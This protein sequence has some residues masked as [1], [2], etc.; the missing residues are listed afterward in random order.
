MGSTNIYEIR[1]DLDSF[2]ILGQIAQEDNPTQLEMADVDKGME[3]IKELG[4][5]LIE[6]FQHEL[7]HKRIQCFNFDPLEAGELPSEMAAA[8]K[9]ILVKSYFD[10]NDIGFKFPKLL[11]QF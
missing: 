8:F 3:G 5:H 10:A 1:G 6:L 7:R 9:L 11:K 4:N 2:L